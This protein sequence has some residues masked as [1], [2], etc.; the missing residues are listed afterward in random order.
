MTITNTIRAAD[1]S[2]PVYAGMHGL[3]CDAIWN[4]QMVSQYTD[5][6]TTHPYPLF[7]P[8]VITV[9]RNL[10]LVYSNRTAKPIL[11]ELKQLKTDLKKLPPLPSCGKTCRR[12]LDGK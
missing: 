6:Q 3:S 1:D 10:G 9:E 12:Y 5:I 11:D 8:D 7:T 4:L 2:R